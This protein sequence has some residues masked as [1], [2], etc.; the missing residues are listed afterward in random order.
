[1][2]ETEVQPVATGLAPRRVMSVSELTDKIKVLLE[3]KFSIIWIT[4]EISNFKIAASGHAYLTLKDD[5]AQ[6]SAVLFRGQLRQ[7]KFEP[8][9]GME[10]LGLGRISV[11]PPRGNYQIILEYLEPK[12]VGS[13]QVAF[14]KLKQKLMKEGLFDQRYKKQLPFLVKRLCVVTSAQGAVIRDII[15]VATR[16]F[17]DLQIDLVPVSVQGEEAEAQIVRAIEIANRHGRADVILIARGGG[18][19]ED[20]AP[21]NTEKVARAIFASQIPIVSAVG[22]EVDFTIADFV[23]D[24][25]APTPSA[26]AEII[27]PVRRQLDLRLQELGCRMEAALEKLTSFYRQHIEQL[28][29]RLMHPA[30]RISENFIKIDD[31]AKRLVLSWEFYFA[32]RKERFQQIASRLRQASPVLQVKN[33]LQELS[34]LNHRLCYAMQHFHSKTLRRLEELTASLNALN[35]AGILQRGY[36]IVMRKGD[37]KI[38]TKSDQVADNQHLYIWLAQGSLEALVVARDISGDRDRQG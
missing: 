36:S 14:E 24:L 16:R 23:A 7:L 28:C 6:V 11:Y 1:M 31:L 5:K 2:K 34:S 35:P 9:D 13:L 37:R 3:N 10:I 25:R 20:L 29:N 17:P 18:S 33:R 4:G 38:V 12:G 26:A 27:I 22:H 32:G 8:G 30:K 21:F 15:N 19:F